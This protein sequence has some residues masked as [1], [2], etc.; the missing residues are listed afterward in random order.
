MPERILPRVMRKCPPAGEKYSMFGLLLAAL[1]LVVGCQ[2]ANFRV[3][4]GEWTTRDTKGKETRLVFG[5]GARFRAIDGK[6]Q[7]ADG[8][9]WEDFR[10]S[11]PWL[12]LKFSDGTIVQTIV[13]LN[14]ETLEVQTVKPGEERPSSFNNDAI[15]YTKAEPILLKPT[16]SSSKE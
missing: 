14:G 1:L 9:Y 7:K 10:K 15:I 2:T 16:P 6:A 5:P 8:T 11:P 3:L 13:K 12:D 4:E